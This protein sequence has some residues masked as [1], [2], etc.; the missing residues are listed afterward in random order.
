MFHSFKNIFL[1][2]SHNIFKYYSFPNILREKFWSHFNNQC[3]GTLKNLYHLNYKDFVLYIK[4]SIN[5]FGNNQQCTECYLE[6]Y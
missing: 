4:N 2:Y 6:K 5:P 1:L 3:D